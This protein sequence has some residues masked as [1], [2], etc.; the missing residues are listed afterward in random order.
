MNKRSASVMNW[1]NRTKLKLIEYKGG[2]CEICGFSKNIPGCY[3]FHH[4]DPSAKEF[5]ISGKSWNFERL[6]KEVDKCM[7]LCKT[8]HAEVHWQLGQDARQKRLQFRRIEL[9][10]INCKNCGKK[11]K[12]THRAMKFCSTICGKIANRKVER[13]SKS[14]LQ[15]EIL[16]LKNWSALGRKYKVSDNAIRKWARQYNLI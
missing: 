11:V 16:K 9:G 3:D 4:T 5:V 15:K 12:R 8:C 10:F 1:R 14:E 2:K 13:P 6:Q 7:L